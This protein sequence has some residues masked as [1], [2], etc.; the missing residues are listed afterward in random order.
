MQE[1]VPEA[2]KPIS[3][4]QEVYIA[5]PRW[6]MTLKTLV[7]NRSAMLGL[8][9]IFF[10]LMVALFADFIAPYP[11]D[12]SMR[13]T[14]GYVASGGRLPERPPCIHALGC[15]DI[16]EHYMGLDRNSRDQFSRIVYGTRISLTVGLVS[17]SI[18]ILFGTLIGLFSGYAGGW[19]DDITMRFMDVLLAF[20]SLLLAIAIVTLREGANLENA[21]LAIGIVSVPVYARLVR[22]SVL[23]LKELEYITA[24][25]ALGAGHLRIVFWHILPNALT[26]LIVQGTLG[27]GTAV[28]E[29][30]GLS[31]LGVGASEPIPEWGK[32]LS[33]ARDLFQ[34]APHLVLFPGIAITITVLGFNLLG[35]GLRDVFDPRLRGK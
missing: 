23:S 31:F 15:E 27:I 21:M 3:L 22:S 4:S 29:T 7:S 34:N 32:M 16:S 17:V 10:L 35:D 30:A 5:R 8:F 11:Y 19:F 9:I 24:E 26:P 6:V 13:D 14:P 2:N 12:K 20:P 1:A 33:D 18:A 25:R 28:I